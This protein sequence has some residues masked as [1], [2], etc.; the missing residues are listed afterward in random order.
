MADKVNDRE[1]KIENLIKLAEIR[2]PIGEVEMAISDF[3]QAED[4]ATEARKPGKLVKIKGRF[5][6]ALSQPW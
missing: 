3:R 6:R 1:A 2:F 4:M 5:R